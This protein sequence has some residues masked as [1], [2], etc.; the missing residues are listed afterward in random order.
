M[1]AVLIIFAVLN[2]NLYDIY[3][4]VRLLL[5]LVDDKPWVVA[6][7]GWMASQVMMTKLLQ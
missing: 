1:F 6:F 2:T 7:V 3:Y 4:T 5:L